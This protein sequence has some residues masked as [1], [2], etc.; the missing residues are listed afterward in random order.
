MHPSPQVAGISKIKPTFFS[1]NL[2]S[3]S[4]LRAARSQ[5]AL[6]VTMSLVTWAL[7]SS[8]IAFSPSVSPRVKAVTEAEVTESVVLTAEMM[9]VVMMERVVILMVTILVVGIAVPGWWWGWW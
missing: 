8:K 6:S 4:A 1:T 7:L 9:A 5:T 2:A 3:L